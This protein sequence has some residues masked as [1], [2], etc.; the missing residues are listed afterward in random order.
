MEGER[1]EALAEVQVTKHA[2]AGQCIWGT[3]EGAAEIR[4]F[5]R[6]V[7]FLR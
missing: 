6:S 2:R 1:Q 7:L 5:A 4:S 3:F